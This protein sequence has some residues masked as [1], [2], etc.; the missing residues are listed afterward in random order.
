MEPGLS[1][2]GK[3]GGDCLASSGETIRQGAGTGKKNQP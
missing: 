2:P 3:T 1:S